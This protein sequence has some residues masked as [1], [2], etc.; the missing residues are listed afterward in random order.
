[1]SGTTMAFMIVLV[2]IGGA[3]IRHYIDRKYPK[4]KKGQTTVPIADARIEAL[5]DR[6]KVLE[7]IVTDKSARLSDEIDG[8]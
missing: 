3:T 8:L 6:I 7:R 4:G 5:E 1:M 2:V